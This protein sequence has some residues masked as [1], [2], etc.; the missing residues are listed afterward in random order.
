[1]SGNVTGNEEITAIAVLKE[2][3]VSP[4]KITMIQGGTIKTVWKV[5][6]EKTDYCLKRLKQEYEK[7][8]FSVN[9]Q[10]YIKKSGGNVPG[11]ILNKKGQS[12]TSINEQLFVLYEWVEGTDL[13]FNIPSDLKASIQG[14]ASFH[15]HSKGYM[16]VVDSRI[17]TKLGKWPEQYASML[18]KLKTWITSASINTVQPH[19]S[20]YTKYTPAMIKLGEHA[21]NRLNAS[22]YESLTAEGSSS[23]V[24]CHQDFG[25]G[26]ALQTKSGICVIDL[27]GVT[28]D[29]PARDLRKIIGK[30]AENKNQWHVETAKEIIGWYNEIN[31]LS[32]EELEILYTDLLFP[33]WYYGLVKNLF[34]NS[35]TLKAEQ[36]ERIAKLEE[37]KVRS[38]LF[39]NSNDMH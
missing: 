16:P 34:Q 13:N 37:S 4:L 39:E 22:K 7:A 9:A 18:E 19:Y 15:V 32:K 21:L 25:K 30:N 12:I 38:G 31:P 33:H 6:T 1:M 2:Y 36:I 27:D 23:I 28:Y 24:L 29:L 26:N 17:S 20:A 35:K 10:I 5:R 8:L 11:I 14:L 3:P